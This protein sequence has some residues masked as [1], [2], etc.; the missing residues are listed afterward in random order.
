MKILVVCSSTGGGITSFVL[1]QVE[2]LK[3]VHGITLEYAEI[4][5]KG[6]I[7]YLKAYAGYLKKIISNEYDLVHA[8][9][10]LSGLMACMQFFKPVVVTFHGCDVNDPKTRWISRLAYRLCKHAV[11]VEAG[12]APKINAFKKQSVI[13]CGVDT[14]VFKPMDKQEARKLLNLAPG[15]KVA[16]FSSAFD[17]PVKNYPLAKTVCDVIPGL[18]LIELKNYGR[19]QVSLL[20][21]AV[22]FLLLTS[23]RE[24]SPQVIKEAL[25]CNCPIVTTRVGDVEARLSGAAETYVCMH[26]PADLI[27]KINLVL[28]SGARAS[29]RDN[30]FRD[31]LDLEAIANKM[32]TIYKAL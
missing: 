13:P 12:M 4:K 5:S 10:G 1:E 28:A 32:N 31:G 21:N 29:G 14:D 18:Q 24:G 16:L 3:K 11:F 2:S 27:E 22:D 23:I 15:A 20:L 17:V 8:H 30:I 25:S 26:E 7:G 19:A 9:Y 6:L